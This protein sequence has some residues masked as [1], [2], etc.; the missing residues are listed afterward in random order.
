MKMIKIQ[1]EYQ[2]YPV[3][4]YDDEDLVEEN[5]LPP[6][7]T[8][9]HELDEKFRSLQERFD[10]TYVDTPTEF[11]NRGF[12]SSE[13]EAAFDTDLKAAVSEFIEKCPKF[14]SVEVSKNLSE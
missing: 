9:D 4:I 2:C 10:E 5:S 14:Y 3:W 6:E 1:L 7:L 12:N 13:D 11:F 8:D